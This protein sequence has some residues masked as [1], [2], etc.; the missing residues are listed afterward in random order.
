MVYFCL[1]SNC[2]YATNSYEELIQHFGAI[3][4]M[5]NQQLQIN[6]PGFQFFQQI[7]QQNVAMQQC[8]NFNPRI[9]N[10]QFIFNA[11]AAVCGIFKIIIDILIDIITLWN[12]CQGVLILMAESELATFMQENNWIVF[13]RMD[14]RTA[15]RRL[16]RFHIVYKKKNT[17]QQQSKIIKVI[18]YC[19]WFRQ[20]PTVLLLM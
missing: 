11:P 8:H 17:K 1:F 9:I 2:N 19:V 5:N 14:Q 18:I 12:I 20:A 10:Q 13:Q 6:L 3:H 15:Q 4:F 7:I 16:I